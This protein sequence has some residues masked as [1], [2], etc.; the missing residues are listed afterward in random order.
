[1]I[2]KYSLKKDGNT[3][4]TKDFKVKEFACHDGS[5]T[6]YISDETVKILQALRD[7]FG[8]PVIINSGY[9]TASYNKKIGGVSNSQHV[10]GTACDIKI[11]GVPPEAIAAYLEK[12]FPNCGIGL[13]GTFV[14]ID[15]RGYKSYWKNTGSNTVSS[16]KLGNIYEKYKGDEI[17]MTKDELIQLVDERIYNYFEE[18]KKKEPHAYSKEAREWGEKN[19]LINGDEKG[20]RYCM[21]ETREENITELYRY[22]KLFG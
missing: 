12:Y 6:I 22:N 13:Y 2:K 17:D 21:F 11:Q 10:K 1:M 18:L 16:F 3:N 14:H 9:R 5:D 8:K 15:T 20:M 7:Y 4:L 19:G